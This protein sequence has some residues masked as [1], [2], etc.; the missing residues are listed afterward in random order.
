MEWINRQMCIQLFSMGFM[1]NVYLLYVIF[2]EKL[3]QEELFIFL[4]NT[5][6]NESISLQYQ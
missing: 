6:L 5:F 1:F 2:V 3:G 4:I